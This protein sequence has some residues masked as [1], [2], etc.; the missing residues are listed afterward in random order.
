MTIRFADHLKDT[1]EYTPGKPLEELER[2]LG[3]REAIKMV[4]NENFLGPSHERRC[5]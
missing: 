2:E 4:S 3:I 5:L 1:P